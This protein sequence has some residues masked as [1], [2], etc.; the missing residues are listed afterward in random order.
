MPDSFVR[1]HRTAL[2]R[3]PEGSDISSARVRHDLFCLTQNAKVPRLIFRF[4]DKPCCLS[5]F[6]ALS[7]GFAPLNVSFTGSSAGA[8]G[9]RWDFGDGN[10]A[11]DNGMQN[12]NHIYQL[13]GTYTVTLTAM[14]T[15]GNT[16]S[17]QSTT[18]TVAKTPPPAVPVA[19]FTP[20][21]TSGNAPLAVA[22]DATT[23]T[24][25]PAVWATWRWSFGDGTFSSLQNPIHTYTAGGTYSVNLTATNLGG[26]SAP[27]T[28]SIIVTVVGP[29]ANFT[30]TPATGSA[31]LT[32]TF[33]DL[34]TNVPTAWNWTFGDGSVVNATQKNPVHTYLT[35]GVY[36]V[37][38]NASNSGGFGTT[39]KVGYINVTNQSA[40]I[41]IFRKGVFYLRNSPTVTTSVV[42]GLPTDTPIVG[43]WG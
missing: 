4:V 31:P 19:S 3:R 29:V 32:V 28:G 14:T 42:Y 13:P 26:T 25:S 41:G 39:T 5:G 9:W 18:I 35:P 2:I 15:G 30:G 33:T 24:S 38:L 37:S 7:S 27:A 12:P 40:S 34:S 36:D 1:G 23:S 20:N 10:W 8:T 43:K 16:T 6:P 21:Q 17:T 11:G 22:F